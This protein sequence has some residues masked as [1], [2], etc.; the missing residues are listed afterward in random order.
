MSSG[1]DVDA[2][3]K[4]KI[5]REERASGNETQPCRRRDQSLR[6]FAG[7]CYRIVGI[8]NGHLFRSMSASVVY[9][10]EV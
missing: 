6:G 1:A 5:D 3:T 8:P 10:A 7:A 2:W 4:Y 9:Q